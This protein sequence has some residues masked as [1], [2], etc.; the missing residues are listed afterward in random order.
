MSPPAIFVL[1]PALAPQFAGMTFPA[2]RKLLGQEATIR[3]PELGDSRVVRPLAVGAFDGG[4]AVGLALAEMPSADEQPAELLSVF[5]AAE[6]RQCGIATAL[7][8]ETEREL[9]RLGCRELGVTYTTGRPGIEAMEKI[10]AARGWDPP[11]ART[12]SVRFH[13]VEMLKISILSDRYLA[14]VDPGFEIFPWSDLDPATLVALRESN[15]SAPWISTGLEPW[16]YPKEPWDEASSVGARFAGRVVGWTLNQRIDET[17]L[18]MTC[19][20]LDKRLSRRGRILPLYRASLERAAAAGIERCTFLT[21]VRFPNMVRFI[22]K[23]M[24]PHCE[25]VGETRGTRRSL[26]P[27]GS[28]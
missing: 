16:S 15:E 28:G 1:P 4:R 6:A 22:H 25:F 18:R 19:S 11:T 26:A 9:A 17:T 5:V 8:A 21:P 27:A 20:F 14:E 13:P 24:A 23:W 10:F 7:V 2:Y 12:V 3:H